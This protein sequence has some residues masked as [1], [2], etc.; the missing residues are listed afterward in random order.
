[1]IIYDNGNILGGAGGDGENAR[2]PQETKCFC[3]MQFNSEE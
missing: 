2:V 3:E 1:M